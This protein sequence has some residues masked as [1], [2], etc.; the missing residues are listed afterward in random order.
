MPKKEEEKEKEKDISIPPPPPELREELALL[1]SM[2]RYLLQIRIDIIVLSEQ[3]QKSIPNP[4]TLEKL[5]IAHSA[6][7]FL[8]FMMR[9]TRNATES[10]NETGK[11]L[12]E[13]W[14]QNIAE[15]KKEKEK[16]GYA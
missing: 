10:K 3:Y 12:E 5:D 9:G 7:L 6:L 15:V 4:I 13:M 2:I 14:T 11:T 1:D 8:F 16:M